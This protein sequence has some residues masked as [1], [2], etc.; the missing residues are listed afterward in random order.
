[1]PTHPTLRRVR[2]AIVD[3]RNDAFVV[4]ELVLD[5]RD[6]NTGKTLDPNAQGEESFNVLPDVPIPRG[7]GDKPMKTSIE[8]Q[9]RRTVWLVH[10]LT[11]VS[12]E[13]P[14]GCPVAAR[15]SACGEAGR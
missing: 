3:G 14:E 5:R 7:V 12:E 8:F 10:Q 15:G 6:G 1:V 13:S 2:V 9:V 11:S 4:G